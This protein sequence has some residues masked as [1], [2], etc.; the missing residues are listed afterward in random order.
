MM[1][2]DYNDFSE[3]Q[4]A[5][6][7]KTSEILC[8]H[9]LS[10]DRMKHLIHSNH[11]GQKLT[12]ADYGCSG[13]KN[14][15]LLMQMLF[16]KLQER[17]SD[18]ELH[19]ILT[20]LPQNDFNNVFRTYFTSSLCDE[21]NFSLTTG[22]GS[23]YGRILASNSL[24]LVVST[25]T[26]HWISH[27]VGS[28]IR[29]KDPSCRI[30]SC[31]DPVED[32]LVIEKLLKRTKN[33]LQ[34]FFLSRSAELKPGGLLIFSCTIYTEGHL[35][36]TAEDDAK[37]ENRLKA[38]MEQKTLLRSSEENFLLPAV[39]TIAKALGQLLHKT[40]QHFHIPSYQSATN[41]HNVCEIIPIVHR[42]KEDVIDAL[43]T[44]SDLVNSFTILHNDMHNVGNSI[45]DNY[46]AGV[47]SEDEYV[48][49]MTGFIRAWSESFIRNML[50]QNEEAVLWFYQE[51]RNNMK[52][53]K[54]KWS[55][56]NKWLIVV[57]QKN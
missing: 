10:S 53:E 3:I 12:V 46:I 47:Y 50:H 25:S 22:A 31:A 4:L 19:A 20:D 40:Q 43:S 2:L 41:D 32:A 34:N 1:R 17:F 52:E 28:D 11:G 29:F 7:V 21:K 27:P 23:A 5:G 33:D 13:G 8:S 26:L 44:H 24:D 51:M 45:W 56:E 30:I 57:L 9:L 42:C 35:I 6:A 14:S 55:F 15:L 18:L 37:F 54:P 49:K 39:H 16:K 38:E 48:G 36:P